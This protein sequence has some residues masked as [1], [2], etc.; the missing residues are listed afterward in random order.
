MLRGHLLPAQVRCVWRRRLWPL[1]I[2][3]AIAGCSK[4]EEL[5]PASIA[6]ANGP[7]AEAGQPQASRHLSDGE[8]EFVMAGAIAAHEMRR[9]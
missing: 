9:P 2:I 5:T 8:G 7:P 4:P 1:A 3:L 6:S